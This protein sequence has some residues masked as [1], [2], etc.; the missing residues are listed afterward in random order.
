MSIID[1]IIAASKKLESVG[2]KPD[3]IR[4]NPVILSDPKLREKFLAAC[5]IYGMKI[6]VAPETK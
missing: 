5:Q 4:V 3:C 6:I 1:E 2:K